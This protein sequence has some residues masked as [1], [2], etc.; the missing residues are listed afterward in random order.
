MAYYARWRFCRFNS[1]TNDFVRY[2]VHDN[3][4]SG[5]VYQMIED[6][7]GILWLTTNDGLV[8]FEPDTEKIKIYTTANGLL[9]DQFN[10]RSSFKDVNGTIYLGSIDGFI[11][12]NPQTFSENK[13]L[14]PIVIT[15]FQLFG[16]DVLVG[17]D[18]SPLKKNI[19]FLMKYI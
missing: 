14:P 8:R 9:G 18:N 1:E 5:V 4:S 17:G 15:D 11:S 3:I 13:Y 7:E 16:K 19:T 12:F 2:G 6:N 10:Y